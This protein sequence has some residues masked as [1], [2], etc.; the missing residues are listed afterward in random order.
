MD[1][2]RSS[3][4]RHNATKDYLQDL[5]S[6]QVNEY[7]EL[8]V[9][10]ANVTF[11]R[12]TEFVIFG[13]PFLQNYQILLFCV[14]LCIYLFTVSGNG[15]IFFL[16][17]FDQHLHTP[18]YFFV[19]NLSF[20]DMS[21]TSVTIPKMLAKFLMNLDT[22][23]YNACFAQMYI[24]L[25]LGATECLLL[26]VMAYDRYIAICSPL[27]YHTIMTRKVYIILSIVAWS[28]GFATPLPA[29]L[30][31]LK[32]P[33]CGPN[34]IH[35]Y[36]CDH[37]P[38]LQLAC[39][40]TSFNVAVGS[41]VGALIILSSFSLIVISYIKIIIAILKISSHGGRKKT[42]STCASHFAVVNI[43]F[44]PIMFMYIRPTASY[45]SDVD[46]L[47]AMLYTVL[48]PMMNPIIYSLRNKDIKMAFQKKIGFICT[49]SNLNTK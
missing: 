29:T 23:S 15:I 20:I 48:T 1:E 42:F 9:A 14:L 22:I 6:K 44:L 49:T 39:A 8:S 25:T 13:F 3:M 32:L 28:G 37:P 38:L 40:N 4:E 19:S 43:F 46:S 35:H 17:I 41:S 11:T 30:L 21:Y 31:S 26:A 2:L 45:S 18:M 27:H 5:P 24:F 16:V 36:Y 47:V 34:I 7:D 12:V 10:S 33:F